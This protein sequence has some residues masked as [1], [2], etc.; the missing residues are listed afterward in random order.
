MLGS[1]TCLEIYQI[2]TR[3]LNVG[4][5]YDK[6]VQLSCNRGPEFGAGRG[7]NFQQGTC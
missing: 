4:K 5:D 7:D 1:Q 6:S 2:D 3:G